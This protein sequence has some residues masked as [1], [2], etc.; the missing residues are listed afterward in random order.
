M[1]VVSFINGNCILEILSLKIPINYVSMKNISLFFFLI[2]VSTFLDSCASLVLG[3]KQ[4]VMVNSDPPG[5]EIYV[6]GANTNKVTP[7]EVVVKRKVKETDKNEKNEQVY[8]LKK[9]GY[10]DEILKDKATTPVI[11][12][13]DI[14]PGIAL[15]AI[16]PIVD[17]VTGANKQYK[18]KLDLKLAKNETIIKK[19][20]VYVGGNSTESYV[21]LKN[22]DVDKNIPQNTEE[23]PYRFAL[24]IGNEDY[25]SQQIDLNSEI[26]V[27]YARNDASAF[28]EY[29]L[30]AL[31]IPERNITFIL[32]GTSGKMQQAISKMNLLIKNTSGKAEVFVYY[33]GHGLPDEVTKEAYIMPVDVSGKDPTAGI[34]LKELY[35]DLTEFPSR[36]I[37]VFIDACFSGGARNQGLIAARGV[38]IKPKEEQLK[39][40]LIV[41]SASSGDQSS[42]PY[43]EK[44][45]GMFTYFLLKKLQDSKGKITYSDLSDY[46]KESVSL[47]SVLINSKEQNPQTNISPAALSTWKSWRM[48]D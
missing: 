36:K 43:K 33:A 11:A 38:K 34:Q 7:A 25:A 32:D 1:T 18:P 47:N 20:I 10:H 27:D 30:H 3:S 6:N 46:I 12:V 14:Y 42:L 37:S 9:D 26:N 15:F 39:G 48:D 31:G 13:L 17:A 35:T 2:V 21:F 40:N 23:H 45:H 28:K 8:T 19:E 22:S 4:Q 24:I 16:P 29:A 5:A 41:F 44:E